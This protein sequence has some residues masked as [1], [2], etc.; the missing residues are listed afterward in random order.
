MSYAPPSST[1]ATAKTRQIAHLAQQLQLLSQRTQQ[2]E[3][4]TATT[5]AQANYMR[6]LG[7]Y[8]A[9]WFMAAQRIMTPG[10]QPADAP[11]SPQLQEQ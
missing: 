1:P 9:G 2:L 6:L 10:D 8:H 11:A 3:Q 7:G 5:A 4:L